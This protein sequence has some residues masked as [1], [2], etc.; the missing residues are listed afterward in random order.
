MVVECDTEGEMVK[1]YYESRAIY[2]V[3]VGDSG[4][5]VVYKLETEVVNGSGKFE[6]TGLGNNRNTKESIKTAFSYFKAN[7][8]NISASISTTSK[9]YLMHVQDVN[10][11]GMTSSL[12]LA[13]IIAM[14]SGA[15]NKAVQSQCAVLGAVSIGGT[16]NKVEDLASTL[17]MCFDAGAKKMLIAMVSAAYIATVPPELFA[18]FQIMFYSQAEYAVFM[19]LGV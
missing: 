16:I 13:A 8:K 2:T 7:C 14:C 18:K 3:G 17:Q 19:A 15:L 6:S 1:V 11:V 9:D 5:L 10:G 12:S 4:M